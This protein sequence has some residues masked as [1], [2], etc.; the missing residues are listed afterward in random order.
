[1]SFGVSFVCALCTHIALNS[2]WFT[3]RWLR[4]C[5]IW[6]F[7]LHFYKTKFI[8]LATHSRSYYVTLSSRQLVE[9]LLPV[10]YL[11]LS[12]I[13]YREMYSRRFLT[14]LLWLKFI[15]QFLRC[16]TS[17]TGARWT[18]RRIER[19][20]SRLESA[21]LMSRGKIVKWHVYEICLRSTFAEQRLK[22]IRCQISLTP[23]PQWLR[24]ISEQGARNENTLAN[25]NSDSVSF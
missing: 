19:A 13:P 22:S 21:T 3:I 9:W 25:C 2:F 17:Q 16:R 10:Q 1:M 7:L 24:V 14:W 18:A 15:R 8:L 6:L 12:T 11:L 20:R 4:R 5:R 23:T